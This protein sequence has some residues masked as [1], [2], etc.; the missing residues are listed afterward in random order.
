M[1]IMGEL[2]DD[3]QPYLFRKLGEMTKGKDLPA[4]FQPLLFPVYPVSLIQLAYEM[5]NSLSLQSVKIRL[6]SDE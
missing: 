3:D 2:R 4:K 1:A 5:K 6:K